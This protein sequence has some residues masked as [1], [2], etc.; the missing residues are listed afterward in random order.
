MDSS[1]PPLLY[2]AEAIAVKKQIPYNVIFEVTRRCNLDCI[3]C[4]VVDH[5]Q[6]HP[7]ELSTEEIKDLLD[8]LA[9]AGTLKLTFSG[10]EPFMRPDFLDLVEYA[11]SL[12]F[13]IDILTNGTLIGLQTVR[14][15][16]ELAIWQVSISIL[17]A[18]PAT[19]DG[20]TGTPGSYSRSI[21][22]LRLLK[23][24]GIKPR[25]KTLVMKQNFEEYPRII[26]IANSLG[27][28]YS[29]DPTV[30]SRNDGSTD[31][32]DFNLSEEQFK[33]LVNN[34]SL[35]PRSL[36]FNGEDLQS[37]R[38]ERL[39]GYLCKAG[40]SFCDIS[41]NGDVLP[42]MQYQQS[43]GNVREN[44]FIDIWKE[45]PLFVMLRN[46]RRHDLPDC[47]DCEL[48]PLCFR[49]PATAFLETGDPLAKYETACMQA[50]LMEEVRISRMNGS[51][52]AKRVPSNT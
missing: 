31:T 50:R 17:G 52:N 22:A 20:I 33:A 5:N 44:R 12:A 42:C 46:A 25:I 21:Q 9:D 16:K 29:L 1:K 11:R 13:N 51:D 37:S 45:S 32:L 30:S 48:L 34:P 15:L 38:K 6:P 23:E 3:M 27:I 40:I 41:W 2:R 49:C 28:P 47:K 4:Y 7:D 36:S 39:E 14:R 24:I 35:G 18:C 19:H 26:E 10:G 8:Q 43:A